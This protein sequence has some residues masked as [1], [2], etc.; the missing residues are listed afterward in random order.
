MPKYTTRIFDALRRDWLIDIVQFI[1]GDYTNFANGRVTCIK[2]FYN[3]FILL[4]SVRY[5]PIVRLR[6]QQFAKFAY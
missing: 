5:E 6:E 2:Q 3:L 1:Y 4:R